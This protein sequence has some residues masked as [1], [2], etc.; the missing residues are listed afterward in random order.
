MLNQLFRRNLYK[1]RSI[2]LLSSLFF[3]WTF[4]L[5]LALRMSHCLS[6]CLWRLDQCR[7]RRAACQIWPGHSSATRGRTQNKQVRV[8][9]RM[10]ANKYWLLS[11]LGGWTLL[12]NLP[13]RVH[14]RHGCSKI[15]MQIFNW[16]TNVQFELYFMKFCGVS[17]W[18]SVLY[19]YPTWRLKWMVLSTKIF[20]RIWAR[21][22]NH[23]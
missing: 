11:T 7:K 13:R 19:R 4:A 5:S 15:G 8:R 22:S 2:S 18:R 10:D 14:P 3:L 23:T 1:S 21:R 20:K 12:L 9:E 16:L 17:T 6:G